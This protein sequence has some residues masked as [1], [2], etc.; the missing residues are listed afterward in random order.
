[1][2]LESKSVQRVIETGRRLG[3]AMDVLHVPEGA[4]TAEDA[5]AAI[6]CEVAAIVKSLVFTVD[7]EPVVALVPGDRRLDADALAALAGG[8]TVERASLDQ[9]RSATGGTPPIGHVTELR[10]F[11]DDA[12]RRHDPVWAAAGSP[13]TVFPIAVDELERVA[14]AVWGR[15]SR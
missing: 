9:V 13:A 14:N 3:L 4:K 7:G 12:L 1:M 10:V 8:G 2:S 6:G 11:A 15:L 5:A